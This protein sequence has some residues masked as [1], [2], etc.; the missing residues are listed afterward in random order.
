MC[1]CAMAGK[2]Y[3]R[4]IEESLLQ[5]SSSHVPG[6]VVVRTL[7]EKGRCDSERV[8]IPLL[9][10]NLRKQLEIQRSLGIASIAWV[11]HILTK[12]RFWKGEMEGRGEAGEAR[13]TISLS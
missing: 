7:A 8:V 3:L 11:R 1:L 4:A 6:G 5:D 13:L 10:V 12:P 9:G 2:E